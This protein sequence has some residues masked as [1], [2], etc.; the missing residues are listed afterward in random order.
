VFK[1]T[2]ILAGIE[3]NWYIPL[4]N[5]LLMLFATSKILSNLRAYST[6]GIIV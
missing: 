4:L 6:F 3:I 1:G 5:I 2:K